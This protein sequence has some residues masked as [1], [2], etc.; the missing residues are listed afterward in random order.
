M[1]TGLELILDRPPTAPERDGVWAVVSPEVYL[2][3]VEESGW[4]PEQY[5]AWAAATLEVVIPRA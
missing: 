3:A 1:A 2:L 4:S 5:E